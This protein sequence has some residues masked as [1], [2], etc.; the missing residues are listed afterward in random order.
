MLPL[1]HPQRLL[2]LKPAAL[3]HHDFPGASGL[4]PQPIKVGRVLVRVVLAARE[5]RSLPWEGVL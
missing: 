1:D 3:G 2:V 5:R 4:D